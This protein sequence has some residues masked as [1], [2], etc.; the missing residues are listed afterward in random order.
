MLS[1]RVRGSLL[2]VELVAWAT[3]LR[4]VAYDRWITVLASALLFVGAAAALRGKTWGVALAFGQA[5]AFPVAWLIGIAPPW[6]CL[7]GLAGVLPF[8]HLARAF[9]RFDRSATAILASVTAAGGALGAIAWKESAWTV[10]NL[11]PSL[12]PSATAQ[13]GIALA[14]LVALGLVVAKKHLREDPARV[15]IGA[16][17]RVAEEPAA[18][19][20]EADE[21]EGPAQ[22]RARV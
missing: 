2:L 19:L 12:Y 13:H 22:A 16:A 15:R 3:L 17:V 9:A 7:V 10:F 14:V 8:L 6:F 11:F 5:I 18:A 21:V 4:S 20:L 1:S